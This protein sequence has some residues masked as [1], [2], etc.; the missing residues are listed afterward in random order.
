M[1]MKRRRYGITNAVVAV[2]TATAANDGD[3]DAIVEWVSE[4][5]RQSTEKEEK[6]KINLIS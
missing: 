4:S 6:A 2:A 5:A 3:N 1:G